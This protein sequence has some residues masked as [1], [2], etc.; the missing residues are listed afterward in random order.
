M[1]NALPVYILNCTPGAEGRTI[2]WSEISKRHGLRGRVL[3]IEH[4]EFLDSDIFDA[5]CR[6]DRWRQRKFVVRNHRL[7]QIS[8][9][10]TLAAAEKA[11]RRYARELAA[12]AK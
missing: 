5:N 9:H 10:Y 6:Q 4:C 2:T 8:S 12:L 7:E 3:V 1:T 11:A